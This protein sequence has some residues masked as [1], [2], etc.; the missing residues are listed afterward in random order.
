MKKF[1]SLALATGLCLSL[2]T[3]CSKTAKPA[4]SAT[5]AANAERKPVTLQF[6]HAL[7]GGDAPALDQIVKKFNEEN[8]KGITI[9]TSMMKADDMSA[10]IAAAQSANTGLPQVILLGEGDVTQYQQNKMLLPLD[11][12]MKSDGMTKNDVVKQFMDTVIYDN[13]VYALPVWAHPWVLFYNKTLLHQLG[14]QDSDLK[15]LD[16]NKIIEMSKKTMALGKG[17][18]GI[19]LSGADGAVFSRLFYSALYQGGSNI[20]DLAKPTVPTFNNEAG[21]KAIQDSIQLGQYTV[22]KGTAGRP[23]FVDG[24][25]LFHFNGVWEITQLDNKDV[26]AKLDWGVVPFPQLFS[27]KKGVWTSSHV[28]VITKSAATDNEKLAAIDFLKF[29]ENNA[30]IMGQAGHIPT[31]V[32]L[33]N[34]KEFSTAPFAFFKDNMDTFAIPSVG[35]A[36]VPIFNKAV[37]AYTDLYWGDKK[38]VKGTMDAAAKAAKEIIDNQ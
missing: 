37:P 15:N 18:Y 38:D 12:L 30:L 19:S 33:L 22:P 25:V 36:Q 4:D 29:M 11:D 7:T 31:K 10:K 26:K 6:W 13:K 34:S 3:S 32:S 35:A 14:Y 21:I 5:P 17:Y 20:F 24:K 16:L 27:Q 28:A 2:F 23:P 8:G 1:L 9:Q